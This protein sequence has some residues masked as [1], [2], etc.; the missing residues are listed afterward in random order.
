MAKKETIKAVWKTKL[1]ETKLYGVPSGKMAH[2]MICQNS[3]PEDSK[4]GDA[5]PEEGPC[6]E[7]VFTNP[8]VAAVLC[9][10]CVQRLVSLN[11]NRVELDNK[12]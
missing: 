2:A 3:R 12:E 5:A 8:D 9:S 6:T 7:W 10:S 4:Y 11:P 1:M